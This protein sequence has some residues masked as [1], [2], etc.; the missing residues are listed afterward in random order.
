MPAPSRPFVPFVHGR[1]I[2]DTVDDAL[3]AL[4]G[5]LDG[6]GRLQV[7]PLLE[8]LARIAIFFAEVSVAF[9]KSTAPVRYLLAGV[10]A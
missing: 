4:G 7:R 3:P 8:A 2:P 6:Y 1:V 10:Y 9:S 5:V